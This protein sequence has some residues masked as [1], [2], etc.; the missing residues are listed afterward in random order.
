MAGI[1]L[2]LTDYVEIVGGQ[3]FANA[4][5]APANLAAFAAVGASVD[6]FC[7]RFFAANAQVTDQSVCSKYTYS[8]LQIKLTFPVDSIK[9][10]FQC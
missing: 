7:G 5:A 2:C 4:A 8:S 10:P 9:A 6:R 3:T 1:N